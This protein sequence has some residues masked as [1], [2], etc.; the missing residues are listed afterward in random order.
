VMG[1]ASYFILDTVGRYAFIVFSLI[2][3]LVLGSLFMFLSLRRF[4]R[5]DVV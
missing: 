3:P 5:N 1:A 4:Q 2:Y